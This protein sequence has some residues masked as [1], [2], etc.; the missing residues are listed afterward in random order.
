MRYAA[1]LFSALLVLAVTQTGCAD[2]PEMAA[3][4]EAEDDFDCDDV[5]VQAVNP[6]PSIK[7]CPPMTVTVR[8]CRQVATYLCRAGVR[9]CDYGCRRVSP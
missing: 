7:A 2:S 3:V 9:D 1:R 5:T 6:E 4:D 8:A